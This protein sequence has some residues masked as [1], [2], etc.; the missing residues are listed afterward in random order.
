MPNFVLQALTLS[1][2]LYN[3]LLI[4]FLNSKLLWIKASAKLINVNVST[5]SVHLQTV[6]VPRIVGQFMQDLEQI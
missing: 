3:V 1:V 6:S 2:Y 4:V 5:C